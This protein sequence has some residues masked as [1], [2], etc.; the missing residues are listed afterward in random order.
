MIFH[1]IN[2]G[3]SQFS[4]V[5][6]HSKINRRGKLSR[7]TFKTFTRRGARYNCQTKNERV[8]VVLTCNLHLQVRVPVDL[9]NI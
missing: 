2:T 9:S 3:S 7:M 6:I 1:R 8:L 4:T 5:T